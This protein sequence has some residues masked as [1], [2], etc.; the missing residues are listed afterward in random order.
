MYDITIL[1]D[2]KTCISMNLK[3]SF[4]N[5]LICL[6]YK[7]L[8]NML[9]KPWKKNKSRMLALLILNFFFIFCHICCFLVMACKNLYFV[10]FFVNLSFLF[11]SSS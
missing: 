1:M 6:F 7:N 5:Y 3:K 9:V 10:F 4:L 8:P 11:F 2:K